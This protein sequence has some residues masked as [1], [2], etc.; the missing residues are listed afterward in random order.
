MPDKSQVLKGFNVHLFEFLDELIKIFPENMDI[1]TIKTF[2]ELTKKGNV[3]ILIKAWN[4][5]VNKPYGKKLEE[6]DIDYFIDKDYSEDLTELS[7]A[8]EI[9]S[10]IEKIRKPLKGLSQ[11]N[12][13]HTLNYFNNLNKLSGLYSSL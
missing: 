7:N 12:K 13:N 8:D 1:P 11:E 9:V 5:Y 2:F 4:I 10:S 6:G 3:T